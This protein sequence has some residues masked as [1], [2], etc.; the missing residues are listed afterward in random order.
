MAN[1]PASTWNLVKSLCRRRVHV[2]VWS[3][4]REV[5]KETRLPCKRLTLSVCK[6]TH[7]QPVVALGLA[8]GQPQTFGATTKQHSALWNLTCWNFGESLLDS[9]WN[10]RLTCSCFNTM[11]PVYLCISTGIVC[12]LDPV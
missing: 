11:F 4:T 9:E 7:K 3:R 1:S 10:A 2:R 8:L 5:V 6:A 12:L